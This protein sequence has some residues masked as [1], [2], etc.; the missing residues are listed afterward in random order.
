MWISV[1]ERFKLKYFV[2]SEKDVV[3]I[4]ASVQTLSWP[5]KTYTGKKKNISTIQALCQQHTLGFKESDGFW[6]LAR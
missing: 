3:I 1:V 4:Q 2:Q 5:N 6:H